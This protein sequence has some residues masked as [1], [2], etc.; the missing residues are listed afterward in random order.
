MKDIEIK[1][2]KIINIKLSNNRIIKCEKLIW[3]APPISF[4]KIINKKFLSEKPN[5]R[6]LLIVHLEINEKINHDLQYVTC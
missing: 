3:S 1:N 2:K 4:L 6:N 5:F